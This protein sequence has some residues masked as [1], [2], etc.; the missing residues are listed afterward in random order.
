MAWISAGP[1]T[2]STASCFRKGLIGGIPSLTAL[3][4]AQR[5]GRD[6]SADD[7]Q[8]MEGNPATIARMTAAL[9][10]KPVIPTICERSGPSNLMAHLPLRFLSRAFAG[11]LS[12]CP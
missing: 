5:Q 1:K 6:C 10:R 3:L 7:A 12:A 11:Q 2:A 9:N 8:R 4:D